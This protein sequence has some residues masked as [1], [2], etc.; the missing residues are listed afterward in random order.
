M[1]NTA[2]V[3]KTPETHGK[4]V[5]FKIKISSSAEG[6]F[7]KL[8]LQK[9]IDEEGYM[10]IYVSNESSLNSDVY[11][12][13]LTVTHEHSPL[14]QVNAY[15]PFGL[16]IEGLGYDRAT[17]VANLYG[18]NGMEQNKEVD[19]YST[20]YR[21]YNPA[22]ARFNGVD[23]AASLLASYSTYHFSFNNPVNFNDPSGAMP[24]P[25]KQAMDELNRLVQNENFY[26]ALYREDSRPSY[27]T[28]GRES[29]VPGSNNHWSDRY[30]H[31]GGP[32]HR[33]G[34]TFLMEQV[35]MVSRPQIIL[36]MEF[37]PFCLHGL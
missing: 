35:A 14:V 6:A 9:S 23:P 30:V 22:L 4:L 15:Y 24:I 28:Y 33:G 7:E 36:V 19:L 31:S 29:G 10:Y 25:L 12:D 17:A 32:N 20:A 11:F 37:Q 21:M 3:Y 13:D 8:T 34:I 27:E 2:N 1:P 26:R 18:F 5:L 16:Q